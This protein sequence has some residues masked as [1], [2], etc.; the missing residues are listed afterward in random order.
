[1][2]DTVLNEKLEVSNPGVRGQSINVS[3]D[4]RPKLMEFLAAN[5]IKHWAQVQAVAWDDEPLVTGVTLG[6]AVDGHAVQALL[7]SVP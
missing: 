1:M 2:T 5:G 7:D 3:L 4:F 6:A